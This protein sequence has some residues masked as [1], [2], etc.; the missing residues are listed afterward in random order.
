MQNSDSL[1][2]APPDREEDAKRLFPEF[3]TMSSEEWAARYSHTIACSSFDDYRYRDP[4]LHEWIQKLHRILRHDFHQ[5][6]AYRRQ[7]LTEEE[8]RRI[9][10]SGDEF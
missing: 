8:I 6:D 4:E 1:P 2:L 7:Y 10:Q 5:I 3:K 9:E